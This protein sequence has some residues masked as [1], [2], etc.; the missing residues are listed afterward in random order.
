MAAR[1]YKR[2]PGRTFGLLAA[3]SLWEA[4][5]HLLFVESNRVSESYKRFFYRD[6]RSIVICQTKSGHMITFAL[7]AI[8]FLFG[9]IT[10]VAESDVRAV[11]GVIAGL[12]FIPALLNFL[13]GPTC[14]CTV[15]T[16]VQTQPLPSLNR[17]R[18][19]RKVL[20]RIQPKIASAQPDLQPQ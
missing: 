7:G 12:F 5:D 14:R 16:A 6:I 3:P 1:P 18:V 13:R 19:A 8:A 9:F 10:L 11:A 20:A 15:Q 2:L 17:L 4:D